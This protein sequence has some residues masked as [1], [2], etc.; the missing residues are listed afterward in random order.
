[1]G[2]PVRKS[3]SLGIAHCSYSE[4][5]KKGDAAPKKGITDYEKVATDLTNLADAALFKAKSTGKN[6]IEIASKGISLSR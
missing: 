3:I 2:T 4:R 1:M 5:G 6:T